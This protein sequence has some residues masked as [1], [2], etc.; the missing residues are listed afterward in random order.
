[1]KIQVIGTTVSLPVHIA[2]KYSHT[3]FVD[4][5][6]NP[7][8]VEDELA[9]R[10]IA[11]GVAKAVGGKVKQTPIKAVKPKE[12]KKQEVEDELPPGVKPGAKAVSKK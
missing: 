5:N 7:V 11:K 2:G 10:L 8:E 9:K 6:S 1:M 12:T 4:K 3:V